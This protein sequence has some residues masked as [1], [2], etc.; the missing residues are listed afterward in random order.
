MNAVRRLNTVVCTALLAVGVAACGQQAHPR[1]A[2]ANNN[3]GYVDAGPVTYQLQVSRILN[4]YSTED[5]QY[6]AG[7]PS[8]T[9][10]PNAQQSWYGVF[11]QGVNQT[12]QPQTTTDNFVITD[13][14]GNHYYPLKLNPTANQYAWTSESLAPLQIEPKPGTTASFGPTQG[15]LL[16]FRIGNSAYSNRPLTLEI[17]G[18]GNQPL[19]SISLDL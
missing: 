14:Q 19:A 8:G 1:V 4:P 6:V 15:G 2:D 10:L 9:T 17:L 5:R 16:L 13:T 7:L 12:K 18:S 3:G 11:L